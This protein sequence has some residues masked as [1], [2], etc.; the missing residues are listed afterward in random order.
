[1]PRKRHK[2]EEIIGKLREVEIR[3]PQGVC[4]VDAIRGIGVTEQTYISMDGSPIASRSRVGLRGQ[5]QTSIRRHP[6]ISGRPNGESA[7]AR[8]YSW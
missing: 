5:L 7:R 2:A 1:M 8:L 4:A 6:T 3:V